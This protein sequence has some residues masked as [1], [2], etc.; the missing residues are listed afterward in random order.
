MGSADDRDFARTVREQYERSPGASDEARR[1][2][3]ERVREAQPPR[4]GFDIRRLLHVE[5]PQLRA[6][7]IAAGILVL[8]GGALIS[9]AF[10][11]TGEI[12]SRAPAP[13]AD[14]P[15]VRFQLEAPGAAGVTLVGDFN[16][17]DPAAT[18]MRRDSH[19]DTWSVSL[20]VTR[21]RHVYGFLVDGRRWMPDP[22]APLAPEDGFGTASSVVVVTRTES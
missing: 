9:R 4:R 3:L 21:G 19:Q 17:W 20:P 8:V 12:A 14:R 6:A 15:V 22:A 10:G 16:D 11:P 5:G 13:G 18:P 7:L 1:R 2:L